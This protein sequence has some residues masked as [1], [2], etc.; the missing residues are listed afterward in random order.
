METMEFVVPDLNDAEV[1][2][3]SNTLTALNGVGHVGVD[4]RASMVT[5]DYDP[6]YANPN[7]I[8]G[9]I[10]GAGYRV[11]EPRERP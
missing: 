10:V 1:V 11:K 3:L 6:D 7:I 9:N 4:A 5:V 2:D 8:K